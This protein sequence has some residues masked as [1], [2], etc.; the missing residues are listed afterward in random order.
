MKL[1][2]WKI[3]PAAPLGLNCGPQDLY[4]RAA[5]L[6]AVEQSGPRVWSKMAGNLSGGTQSLQPNNV[7]AYCS[8]LAN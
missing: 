6:M 2:H 1:I 8:D 7:E 4:N 3:L 5:A